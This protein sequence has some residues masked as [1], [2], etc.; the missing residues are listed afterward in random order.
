MISY[1]AFLTYIVFLLIE[2]YERRIVLL[3]Q[4]FEKKAPRLLT[5]FL[6]LFLWLFILIILLIGHF[7]DDHADGRCQE[8]CREDEIVD[9]LYLEDPEGRN[10]PECDY[11]GNKEEK[12]QILSDFAVIVP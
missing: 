8:R 4:F 9:R 1:S 3:N 10:K 2:E 7:F 6:F 12:V 11:I 5:L